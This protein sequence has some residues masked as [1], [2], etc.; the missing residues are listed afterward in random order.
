MTNR[1]KNV[2]FVLLVVSAAIVVVAMRTPEERAAQSPLPTREI[3]V[4]GHRVIV[5]VAD[6]EREQERGL[7]FRAS[8][9]RDRGMLFVYPK[10]AR[11]R[12][13]MHGMRFP[14]DLVF[15]NDSRVVYMADNVQAPNGGIP[16]IVWPTEKADAVLEVNAGLVKELG[17]EIESVVSWSK[18]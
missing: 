3:A 17:I 2:L 4:N 12:F 16:A 1:V 8:L 5:E 9:D 13:W 15:I 10:A 18:D 6:D 11:Q 14:L 7:S